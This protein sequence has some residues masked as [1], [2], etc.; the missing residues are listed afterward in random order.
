MPVR[1]SKAIWNGDLKTGNGQMSFAGRFE[2]PYSFASRF[3]NGIS[4][5]RGCPTKSARKP[6]SR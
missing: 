6:R 3:E 2:Q 1:K 5:I 4:S